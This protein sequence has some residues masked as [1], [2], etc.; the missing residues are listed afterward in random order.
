MQCMGHDVYGGRLPRNQFTVFPD[1]FA[2]RA[3]PSPH[4]PTK[5]SALAKGSATV[6]EGPWASALVSR[7]ARAFEAARRPYRGATGG[8]GLASS[9]TQTQ[10]ERLIELH[11]MMNT[12]DPRLCLL[13]QEAPCSGAS[14]S[15]R[16]FAFRSPPS[17]YN[18]PPTR[19]RTPSTRLLMTMTSERECMISV[20][21]VKSM[22]FSVT[23]RLELVK[24]LVKTRTDQSSAA[25]EGPPQVCAA[26]PSQC[27]RPPFTGD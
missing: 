4:S 25:C 19:R 26:R 20:S 18:P 15:S 27:G 7:A 8:H 17:R 12:H 5:K 22:S 11:G 3:H 21:P 2:V 13:K 14:T 24:R 1:V 6:T 16:Q 23:N 9:R 10:A